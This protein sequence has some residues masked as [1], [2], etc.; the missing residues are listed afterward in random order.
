[1]HQ[2]AA[3]FLRGSIQLHVLES[4]LAIGMVMGKNA[5]KGVL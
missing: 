3:F 2:E 4:I 5:S 1:M